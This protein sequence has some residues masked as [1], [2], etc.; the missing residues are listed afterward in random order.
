M[1][2]QADIEEFLETCESEHTRRAYTR[3]LRDAFEYLPLASVHQLDSTSLAGYRAHLVRDGRGAQSHTQAL[4][5][6]RKFLSWA[7][8]HR[9]FELSAEIAADALRSPKTRSRNPTPSSPGTKARLC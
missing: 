1:S 4:S 7:R 5:A 3:H 9:D 8:I 6:L 2:L